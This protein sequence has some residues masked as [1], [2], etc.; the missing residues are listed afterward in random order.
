MTLFA[1][2]PVALL[3][4]S[5]ELLALVSQVSVGFIFLFAV[6]VVVLALLPSAS[7]G[8]LLSGCCSRGRQYGSQQADPSR[9]VFGSGTILLWRPDGALIAFPM[10]AYGFTAHQFLFNIYSSLKS[11]TVKNMTGVVQQVCEPLLLAHS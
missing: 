4:R 10:I 9:L 7:G 8:E 5:P 11:P 6:V 2:L 1:A 3:V